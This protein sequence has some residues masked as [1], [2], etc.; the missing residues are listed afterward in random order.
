MTSST[1]S[2][3]AT[4]RVEPAALAGSEKTVPDGAAVT[5][6][7]VVEQPQTRQGLESHLEP[8]KPVLRLTL[9]T[10]ESLRSV[11]CAAW[12]MPPPVEI[13]PAIRL[14]PSRPVTH[15]FDIAVGVRLDDESAGADQQGAA[16]AQHG[17]LQ[18]TRRLR[19]KLGGC[20]ARGQDG[21][22]R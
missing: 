5:A 7:G 13:C 3:A 4:L 22:R 20:G 1:M 9:R 8:T 16:E 18:W 12:R 6:K 2:P 10:V 11:F 14:R 21:T 17:E 15:V 19:I